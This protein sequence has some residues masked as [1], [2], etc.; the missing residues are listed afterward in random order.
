MERETEL[1]PA[2]SEYQRRLKIKDDGVCGGES[3]FKEFSNFRHS[4]FKPP[5]NGV[6]V[7]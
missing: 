6:K 5:L 3:R 7:E 1:E 4:A 2:T